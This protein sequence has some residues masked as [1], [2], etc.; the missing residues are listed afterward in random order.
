MSSGKLLPALTQLNGVRAGISMILLV[1]P[2]GRKMAATF[3][4]VKFKAGG[5]S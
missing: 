1:L 5:N 3:L 2:H 4:N